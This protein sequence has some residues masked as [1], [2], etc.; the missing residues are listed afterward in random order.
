MFNS[1][2]ETVIV[3]VPVF[4]LSNVLVA[5]TVIAPVA[6]SSNVTFP[7]LSTI[8][9]SLLVDQTTDLGAKLVVTTVA[10]NCT[11]CPTDALTLFGA[12][13]IEVIVGVPG[14]NNALFANGDTENVF[15]T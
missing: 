13:V 5:V 7:V 1:Q 14:M 11:D 8:A 3:A 2:S 10:V 15:Q 12:S 4:S 9:L 6:P